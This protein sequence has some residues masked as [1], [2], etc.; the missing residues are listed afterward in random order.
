METFYQD[1][2]GDTFGNPTVSIQ[3]YF[4][5]PNYVSDNTD[6]DDNSATTYPGAQEIM[7]D[8]VDN[9]CD[10]LTDSAEVIDGTDCLSILMNNP[11]SQDGWYIIDPFSTGNGIS[12]YCDMT[13]N[14]GG[15]TTGGP[16]TIDETECDNDRRCLGWRPVETCDNLILSTYTSVSDLHGY[17]HCSTLNGISLHFSGSGDLYLPNLVNIIWQN[18]QG[19][20]LYCHECGLS[21]ID[22]PNLVSIDRYIYV[23]GASMLTE[24]NL[25]NLQQVSVDQYGNDGDIHISGD[26]DG[27]SLLNSLTISSLTNVEGDVYIYH[28]PLLCYPIMDWANIV[29]Y[30]SNFGNLLDC[31][32]NQNE[33]PVVYNVKT[34][35]SSY[36]DDLT[37]YTNSN[38]YCQRDTYD[39][40]GDSYSISYTWYINGV[41]DS[42]ETGSYID[43]RVFNIGDTVACQ[44]SVSD[45]INPIVTAMSENTG[46]VINSVPQAYNTQISPSIAT[47]TTILTCSTDTWDRSSDNQQLTI[48]YAWLV[49]GVELT[50]QNTNTLTG[51]SFDKGDVV[52]CRV[53]PYDGMDYGNAV[54]SGSITIENSEPAINSVTVSNPFQQHSSG[55]FAGDLLNCNA[56]G[57]TDADGDALTFTYTWYLNDALHYTGQNL[58]TTGLASGDELQCHVFANDG[59]AN[60]ATVNTSYLTVYII[61]NIDIQNM[62]F[63]PSTVT[64]N[65]GDIVKWTN[66]DSVDHSATEDSTAPLFDSGLLSNG[67]TYMLTGLGV[68][69]YNY[70]CTPHPSMTGTIIVQ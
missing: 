55:I 48:D 32:L 13:T 20:G 17:Y 39:L 64:I 35:S 49:N 10:G 36:E 58:D 25:P 67:Q 70:H 31:D 40:D 3:A 56:G 37:F 9:D 19:L 6:C 47:E 8:G 50:N 62:A 27:S 42:S 45:G 34:T 4:A 2:D 26:S 54:T 14:G 7:N 44:V 29:A 53:T 12:V 15:W 33:P 16:G 43:S 41:V 23:T 11:S 60:S 46:T 18:N 68:G 22:L 66:L 24:I 51:S 57:A 30:S 52:V 21:S 69:T 38:P 65:V 5:P 1:S 61:H 59:T 63:S 28:H